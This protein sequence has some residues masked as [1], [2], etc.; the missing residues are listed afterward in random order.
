MFCCW[1]HMHRPTD[2]KKC[3]NVCAALPAAQTV[4]TNI[5]TIALLSSIEKVNHCPLA[6]HGESTA[7]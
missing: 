7:N 6:L 2:A 4:C 3:T 5:Q 1:L